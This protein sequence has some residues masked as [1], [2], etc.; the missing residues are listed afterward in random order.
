MRKGDF[1]KR[2]IAGAIGIILCFILQTSVFKALAIAGIVPNLL[3]VLTASVGF[4]R[5]SRE[6]MLIG[7]FSGL[8]LD[9]MSGNIIGFFAL[10][11]LLA[12]FFNGFAS[13]IY[14]PENVRLPMTSIILT[15]FLINIVIYIS[16]FLMRG[17]L[18]FPFYLIHVILPEIVYTAIVA[19]VLYLVILFVDRRLV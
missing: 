12:G 17:R 18:D 14:Y 2:I 10:L 13:H 3:I 7:F 15:D 6:G 8:L 19:I 1:M 11:Y 5:G 4:M 9:L 16:M